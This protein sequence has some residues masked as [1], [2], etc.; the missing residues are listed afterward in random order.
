M[1]LID[2]SLPDDA[3]T[4]HQL[5][6]FIQHRALG[7]RIRQWLELEEKEQCSAMAR[8][9][10]QASPSELESMET[11]LLEIAAAYPNCAVR[12]RLIRTYALFL[13]G[14]DLEQINSL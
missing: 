5:G 7:A 6:N 2:R 10:Q 13:H 14:M 4:L 12:R 11:A 1:L 8:Y 9:R 3:A